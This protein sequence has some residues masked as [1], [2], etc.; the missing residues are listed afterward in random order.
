MMLWWRVSVPISDRVEIQRRFF[1]PESL[2]ESALGIR[3]EFFDVESLLHNKIE[4]QKH[5][6]GPESLPERMLGIHGD[7]FGVESLPN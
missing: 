5:F 7:F 4:I 1:G 6:F 2:P 3:S